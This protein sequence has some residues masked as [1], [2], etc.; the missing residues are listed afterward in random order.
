MAKNNRKT[1]PIIAD[2][3]FYILIGL[4]ITFILIYLAQNVLEFLA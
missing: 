4:C 2:I 1:R 3:I